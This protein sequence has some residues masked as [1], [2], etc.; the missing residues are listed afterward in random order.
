MFGWFDA[1][2]AKSFGKKL[3]HG[4]M[5]RIP[6]SD[7]PKD[8]KFEAKVKTALGQLSLLTRS[9]KKEHKLNFYTRAQMGNSFKW[10]LQDAGYE[11][12]YVNEL[13]EWLLLQF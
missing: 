4:F 3:A 9:F 8:K 11:T 1:R 5:E 12:Q 6:L 13:T 7:Q 2:E 10:T